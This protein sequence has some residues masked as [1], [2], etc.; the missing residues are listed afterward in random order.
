MNEHLCECLWFELLERCSPT[1]SRSHSSRRTG[2]R[3]EP[4]WRS[5]WRRYVTFQWAKRRVARDE[6]CRS[7]RSASTLINHGRRKL[8]ELN[9]HVVRPPARRQ[10]LEPS[11]HPNGGQLEFIFNL[12]ARARLVRDAYPE[13]GQPFGHLVC[14]ARHVERAAE[15]WRAA[16]GGCRVDALFAPQTLVRHDD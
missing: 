3:L 12:S 13:S 4:V 6:S 9:L 1:F 2:N 8:A 16:R 5:N 14:A 10:P 15:L 11:G 7:G